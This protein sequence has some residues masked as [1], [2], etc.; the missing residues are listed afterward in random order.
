M[1]RYELK[2]NITSLMVKGLVKS[3]DVINRWLGGRVEGSIARAYEFQED[4]FL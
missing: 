1:A 3:I 4:K 2:K